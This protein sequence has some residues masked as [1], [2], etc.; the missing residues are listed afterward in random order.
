MKMKETSLFDS[1][2]EEPQKPSGPVKVTVKALKQDRDG[3]NAVMEKYPSYFQERMNE[4]LQWKSRSSIRTI[5]R[6]AVGPVVGRAGS[7]Q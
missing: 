6:P 2:L 4:L 7:L 1:L 3:A 5:S